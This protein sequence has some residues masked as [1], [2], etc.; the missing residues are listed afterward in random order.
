MSVAYRYS[1]LVLITILALAGCQ[2]GNAPA[3]PTQPPATPPVAPAETLPATAAPEPTAAPT[4]A[5]AAE[6]TAGP[7]SAPDASGLPAGVF[8]DL[9]EATIVQANFPEDSRFRNMPVRLNGVMAVPAVGEGPFPVVLILHGTH[10]G[11]PVNDMGVDAWP[12]APED[13]R[14]NYAGFEYLTR[15]LAA[16]GYVALAIN[17]NAQNT[18]GFG[19]PSGMERLEQLVDLHLSAL[20]EAAAGGENNFG[21]ELTG[22]PDMEQLVIMGHSRGGEAANWLAGD[23]AGGPDLAAPEAFAEHGYGPVKGLLL[24]APGIAVVGTEGTAVPLSVIISGCDGDVTGG[25]GQI[26]YERVRMSGEP[27]APTTSVVLDR[28]NHNGFNTTLGGDS[29][30]SSE[31]VECA[32]LLDGETQRQ[33]LVDYAGAFL[34]SI[35][36]SDAAARQEAAAQ[37]GMDVTTPAPAEIMG[38]PATVSSLA[39]GADRRTIFLPAAEGDLTTNLL[40][41]AIAAEGVALHFCEE[42]YF[43]PT[44]HPGSEPCLRPNV[45]MPGYPS[46][47]VTSWEQ[48]GGELDF[49]LPGSE[50]DLSGYTALSLRAAVDPLSALNAAGEA[51]SFSIRLTDGAGN[52]AVVIVGPGEPAL[53]FPAGTTVESDALLF[54]P[55]FTGLVPLTTIRVPLAGFAGVDLTNVT[56]I[57]L[58]FDQTPS[59]NLFL[60]DLELV[61]PPSGE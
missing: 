10:P 4:D 2:S 46:M 7:T 30:L 43:V 57:D 52:S 24:I 19:E 14:E 51:Q 25:D 13:E 60:G 15:E 50:G 38:L 9:G 34:T 6:P 58:V 47:V 21:V 54:G 17:I 32:A 33:F 61:R 55:I 56:S 40:G 5:P 49:A 31:R 39:A 20:A 41:G 28:A 36:G 59:G 12:C 1:F 26:F 16:R 45:T 3:T 22:L 11:C 53:A 48:S 8:Y 27:N 18:F 23:F 29:F 44:T 35:F 37:L 42:G